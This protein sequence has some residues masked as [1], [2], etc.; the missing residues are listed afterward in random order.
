MTSCVA[1]GWLFWAESAALGLLGLAVVDAV[2]LA[3]VLRLGNQH[4]VGGDGGGGVARPLRSDDA[5]EASE[6]IGA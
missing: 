5:D 3:A 1:T 2:L 4:Q 6:L